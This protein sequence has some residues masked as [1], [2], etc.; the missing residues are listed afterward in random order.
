VVLDKG[1]EEDWF[2]SSFITGFA[3]VAA[4]SLVAVVIWEL[5]TRHPIIDLRLFRSRTFAVA[6]AMMFVLGVT[7]YGS[8]V[9]LPQFTQLLLGYSAELSGMVLSPG[10][11]LIMVMMPFIGKMLGK[12]DARKMI[13]LGFVCLA[14][15]MLYMSRR[16]YLGIDFKHAVLLR[17]YQAFGL[18][19][20]F[21]PI[22]TLAYA[23]VPREASGA[24]SGLVNLARNMGGD[25]G[26]AIVTTMLARGSQSHQA[27]L[28]RHTSLFDAAFRTRLEAIEAALRA[29]GHDG[30]RAA[31]EAYAMLYRAALVQAQTLAYIDVLFWFG[32]GSALMVPLAFLM[33]RPRP[34]AASMGH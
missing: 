9:L 4:V 19:F 24:V 15:S 30:V 12:V 22:N 16:L 18:A 17:A 5:R 23:D 26:I 31:N 29:A 20:L 34:G 14:A 32:C 11:V 25:V 27:E 21:V 2:H 3:L 8:T 10:G 13:A 28:V 6:A 1:Q 7:L 33:K